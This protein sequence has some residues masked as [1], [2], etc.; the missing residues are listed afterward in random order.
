MSKDFTKLLINMPMAT[1]KV[2]VR[3]RLRIFQ[4]VDSTL[5]EFASKASTEELNAAMLC[6]LRLWMMQ[7]EMRAV[8]KP[9]VLFEQPL[10]Q[11]PAPVPVPSP[12]TAS[13][14]MG[15][16]GLVSLDLG[17]LGLKGAVVH[18]AEGG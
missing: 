18:R 13:P 4:S 1:N 3:L 9:L 7:A 16:L 12:V 6:G 8:G 5:Y 14:S 11:S 15:E 2:D 17:D 10:H